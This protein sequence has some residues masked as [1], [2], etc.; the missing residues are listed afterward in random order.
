MVFIM[1]SIFKFYNM[2][3]Y[4]LFS[5]SNNDVSLETY[6][7]SKIIFNFENAEQ[8][9]Q[10]YLFYDTFKCMFYFKF[11]FSITVYIHYY[12]ILVSDVQHS[13]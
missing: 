11:Y 5:S 12:F 9:M 7:F 3:M 2:F 6:C 4:F 10:H 1:S 8:N 13:G